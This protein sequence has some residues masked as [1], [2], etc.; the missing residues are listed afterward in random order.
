M[1]QGDLCDFCGFIIVMPP[2]IDPICMCCGNN[3]TEDTDEH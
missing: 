1:N 3:V 2:D